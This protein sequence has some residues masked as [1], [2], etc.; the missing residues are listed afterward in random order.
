MHLHYKSKKGSNISA[1][2]TLKQWRI[3]ASI[4]ALEQKQTTPPTPIR[5]YTSHKIRPLSFNIYP[6]KN[7]SPRFSLVSASAVTGSS[8]E[9]DGGAKETNQKKIGH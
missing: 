3:H 2:A 9:I 8:P 1:Y 5:L 7:L 4:N 6:P